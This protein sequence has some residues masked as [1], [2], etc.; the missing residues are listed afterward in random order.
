MKNKIFLVAGIVLAMSVV[1]GATSCATTISKFGLVDDA[2]STAR[3]AD[4]LKAVLYNPDGSRNY[5]VLGAVA[6]EGDWM[7]VLGG[8]SLL[9]GDVY[10]YQDGRQVYKDLFDEART[11]FPGADA[12]I[13]IQVDFKQA[14]WGLG[15]FS[16]RKWS[17]N[18]YAIKF[19]AK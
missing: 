12:V 19:I 1:L 6:V 18:G 8:S 10:L 14:L 5:T 16:T 4:E 3:Q 2:I 17:A 7:G 11:Q 15:I 13:G 9:T